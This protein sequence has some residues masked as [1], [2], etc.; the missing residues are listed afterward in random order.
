[1]YFAVR[2]NQLIFQRPPFENRTAGAQRYI[3]F[4]VDQ[5]NNSSA[6]QSAGCPAFGFVFRAQL[7][8]PAT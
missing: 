1:M 6:R 2:L 7:Q 3:V 5:L 4:R 8:A